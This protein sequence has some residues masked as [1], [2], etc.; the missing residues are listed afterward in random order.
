MTESTFSDFFF[1]SSFFQLVGDL[2]ELRD[3][4]YGDVNGKVHLIIIIVHD[5]NNWDDDH[6][7]MIMILR[8][9]IMMMMM[10]RLM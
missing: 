8:L 9:V 2:S 6:A 4:K 10:I 5:Q 3:K 1:F 7:T